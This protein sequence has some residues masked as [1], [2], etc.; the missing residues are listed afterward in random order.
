MVKSYSRYEAGARFGV[1]NGNSNVSW[2]PSKEGEKGPGYAVVGGLEDVLLWDL[3]TG[4]LKTRMS[5]TDIM[6]ETVCV[7]VDPS[8]Q[9]VASGYS[10]GAVRVWDSQS[11]SLLTTFTGHKSAVSFLRFDQF[12][13]RLA[14]GSRD[15]NIVVWDLVGEVG[16]Y[17]FKGHR[18]QITGLEFRG[19]DEQFLLSC[20]KD[21][22]VKIWDLQIQHCIETHVAH[23]GECWGMALQPESD[24][25]VTGSQR[26]LKMWILDVQDRKDGQ[27]LQEMGSL[28]KQV[29]EQRSVSLKFDKT[30]TYLAV[31]NADK[32]VE[33]WRR[34]S[35]QE[36]KKS[37][38]RKQKRRREKG[39]A[40]DENIKETNVD[41]IYVPHAI[42]RTSGKCRGLDWAY[43]SGSK[44]LQIVVSLAN[45]LVEMFNIDSSGEN[46]KK[47]KKGV[48]AEY[49]RAY[50]IELPGHR[51]DVR[52]VALS[53]DN[54]MLVSA[55]NGTLKLWNTKTS[56]CLRTLD[57][58]Y[59]LCTSFLPGDSLVLTGTKEG[60]LLLHDIASSSVI[61]EVSDAHLG[62]IWSLDVGADG[63]TIVTAGADKAIRFWQI[64]V[65]GAEDDG[66]V[67]PFSASKQSLKLKQTRVLELTDDL[68][69][70]KLSSDGKYLAAS[71]LDNTVK[72]F[73]VDTLKFY[74]NLYGHKLP[75]L[76]IDISH[77]SKLLISCSAD[78]NIKIWG[79]DF[80]DCH[81]SIFAHQDSV[82]KVAFEPLT[83]NFFSVGKD[84]MVKYW[85]GD[86]F[87]QIQR[88]QGHQSEVWALA[89]ASDASFVVSA[90]HDKSIR[91]W[92]LTDDQLFLEE[93]REKELEE[94]YESNLAS[95]LNEGDGGTAAKD[96]DEG[97]DEDTVE[98]AG[99]QTI[100]TLKAG[101]RLLEALEIGAKDLERISKGSSEPR[102]IILQTLNVSAEKYVID[103]L[104]KIKASQLED[105]LLIFPFDRVVTLIEFLSL[106][107]EK[108][109]NPSLVCRVL[110]FVLRLYHK[111]IVAN[112]VMRPTL[113]TLNRR[114]KAC[115]A[116]EKN[117][118]GF[119]LA[120]LTYLRRSW[121]M[122]HQRE[123]VDPAEAIAEQDRL[124]KKRV[125]TTA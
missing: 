57:C 124:A 22:L 62:A 33:V 118:M 48:L 125:F 24:I 38:A 36:V 71:L 31:A 101:E 69:A 97:M 123:F 119:N 54:R 6:H 82:M 55:S 104:Q 60:T 81:K 107:A 40:E 23:R 113:E 30:G 96:E 88:L 108:R 28:T 120:G 77:D 20:S 42:V 19:A 112:K 86:K 21:G 56:N 68:L 114:L 14:S 58:G 74:L 5:E 25:I 80:G 15:C 27:K 16:L 85:D 13:T 72:V 59:A 51:T 9:I 75:V 63:K 41:E 94:M 99:K 70:V 84:H 95:T 115:L 7:A 90:S 103:V 91:I 18:D 106:W 73:F 61:C 89:V 1:V 110:M 43:K 78:K 67:D 76:S 34:R 100:E 35:N 98:R 46:D 49:T 109:W 4:L 52:A 64:K 111:Q 93:E 105:A 102:N 117:E 44:R 50:G 3:K 53:S 17:R 29:S 8:G 39:M 79:L 92:D 47:T 10:D 83:H 45:N 32:S 37:I 12:G 26:E 121:E 87:E 2:I 11:G 65:K 66:N 116:L 122:D